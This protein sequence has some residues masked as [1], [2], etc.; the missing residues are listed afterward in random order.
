MTTAARSAYFRNIKTL[1]LLENFLL[2]SHI[3]SAV[4]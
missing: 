1:I 2:K 4:Q 3:T